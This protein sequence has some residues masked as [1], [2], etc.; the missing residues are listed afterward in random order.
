MVE[1]AAAAAGRQL[2]VLDVDADP[3]LSTWSD[4]VPVVLIDGVL[5]ARWW[6][7]PDALAEALRASL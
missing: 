1:R 3:A 5:H 7:D 6:V 4:H 2:Q